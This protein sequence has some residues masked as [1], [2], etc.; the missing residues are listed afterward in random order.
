MFDAVKI[1][2]KQR[3]MYVIDTQ[4]NS[5]CLWGTS[6]VMIYAMAR[7]MPKPNII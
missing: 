7:F 2:P 3:E 5:G 4:M 1:V 6:E